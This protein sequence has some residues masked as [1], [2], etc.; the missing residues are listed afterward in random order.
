MKQF[1]RK[2]LSLIELMIGFLIIG[3]VTLVYIQ[4]MNMSRQKSKF[5]SE[6]FLA[7]LF[8]AK[9]VENCQQETDINPYGIEALGLSDSNGKSFKAATLITDGQ[10]VFFKYPK[11]NETDNPELFSHVKDDFLLS[12]NADSS[13]KNYYSVNTSFA[14]NAAT[15]P[16]KFSCECFF[17][18]YVMKKAATSTF[19]FPEEQLEK[20]VVERV[21]AE[22][23]VTLSSIISSPTAAE[24]ARATGRIYFSVASYLGSTQFK[25]SQE[26][27]QKISQETLSPSSDRYAEGTEKYFEIARDSFDLLL[28]LKPHIAHIAD[29]MESIAAMKLYHKA[30][31]ENYIYKSGIILEKMQQLFFAS[32]N[33]AASRYREQIKVAKNLR[34]QRFLIERSL[35]MYRILYTSRKFCKDVFVSA[36]AE[37]VIKAEYFDFLNAISKHFDSKDPAIFRL[38]EQERK[39]AR[40]E[41]LRQRYFLCDYVYLLFTAVEKMVKKLPMPATGSNVYKA[42]VVGQPSGDGTPEGAVTWARDQLKGGQKKGL[43]VNNGM[44][45]IDKSSWDNWCLAFVATA[46]GRKVANLQTGSAINSL[47]K[48][49]SEGKLKMDK[50]PPAGAIIFTGA[51]ASNPHGHIF[52]ATGKYSGT[53]DPIVVTTGAPGW[54]GVKEIPLSEVLEANGGPGY[55]RGWTSID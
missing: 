13:N 9:V 29:N 47:Q 25:K 53:D 35:S 40:D 42:S 39:F 49:D 15:G 43:N 2:G 48:Y 50:R 20:K 16:G 33:E 31:L 1:N 45:S 10:S 46:Y 4:T 28:Y 44:T 34:T 18:N 27:A 36:N 21:L 23:N 51:T 32:I 19:A 24:V 37:N 54:S 38:V 30:Q 22:K 14:W 11:I 6:H 17:P 26:L 7:A 12:V 55:Y 3:G 41:I 8:A 5:Y 52:I